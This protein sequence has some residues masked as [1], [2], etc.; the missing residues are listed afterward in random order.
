M[1][2]NSI[3]V[4]LARGGSRRIPKKNLINFKNKPLISWTIEAAIKS[5]IFNKVLV[6]TDCV[7]IA[8]ISKEY[9]ASVPFLRDK[10][11]D[12]YSKSSLATCRALEQAENFWSKKF[13]IVAQLMA[14]CPLRDEN[15]I[16]VS[17]NNFLTKN[18]ISQIS[19]FKFGWMNPWWA[20]KEK[21]K[22]GFERL[23]PN[24]INERSQDLPDLFCPTG[25][26][27]I[28]RRE[29]LLKNKDFYIKESS[30]FPIDWLSAVDIDNSDDLDMAKL[31]YEFKNNKLS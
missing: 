27:W 13:D 24:A 23:F 25:A 14:N 3:A 18:L 11:F 2:N 28:T 21:E 9:G 19:C 29:S 10:A 15:D 22:G 8:K 20:L 12:D 31:C 4:I 1:V 5:K 6:S 17:M 7:E 30:Y 16:K 26:I